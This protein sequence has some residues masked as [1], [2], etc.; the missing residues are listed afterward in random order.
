[1]SI[2]NKIIP[3]FLAILLAACNLT[4][5][6]G[7]VQPPFPVPNQT[8]TALFSTPFPTLVMTQPSGSATETQPAVPSQTASPAANT[9]VPPTDTPTLEPSATAAPTQVP[10]KVP[11]LAPPTSTPDISKRT[12]TSVTAS[13]MSTKPSIDGDWNDLPS[14]E[15][16]AEIVVYGA[17][18]WKSRD[19]L[20]A[21]FKIGWDATYLYLG[22]KVRDDVYVQNATGVNLFKGDS[23]EILLDTDVSADY[24][25]TSL[26]PDDFQLGIS[27]GRP[28]VNGTKEAYLWLPSNIAGSRSQVKIAS[29]RSDADGITRIEVAIPWTIFGVTPKSGSH[30][31]FVLSASD[32]DKTTDNVQQSM[33][34]NVKTRVLVDP[35]TWGDLTL[36]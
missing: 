14:K 22:V 3:L 33:V 6:P 2:K 13:F 20:A 8:M 36:K 21:S 10:T 29:Q 16:P 7:P 25:V 35:T 28:D 31:G 30:F 1:M 18:N 27:D 11:T 17:A 5:G 15:Y 4:P 19:D 34:S 12:I 24:Y 32:N 9:P 23:L 26:S